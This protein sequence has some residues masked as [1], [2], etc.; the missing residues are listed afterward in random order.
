[1]E[2]WL[3]YKE[4]CRANAEQN[5]FKPL[6]TGI[7]FTNVTTIYIWNSFYHLQTLGVTIQSHKA[8]GLWHITIVTWSSWYGLVNMDK[9]MILC[10]G[11]FHMIKDLKSTSRLHKFIRYGTSFTMSTRALQWILW[12]SGLLNNVKRLI[13]A[14]IL[15]RLP[16][17]CL[18]GAG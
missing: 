15:A 18:T 11:H 10:K 16:R 12:H 13:F 14:E 7:K 5:I 9:L 17:R 8:H 6:F 1:M 4:P 2:G 3:K